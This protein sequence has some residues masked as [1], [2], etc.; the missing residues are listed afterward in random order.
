MI[1]KNKFKVPI[2]EYTVEVELF[3]D[4]KEVREKYPESFESSTLGCTLEYPSA[5]CTVIVPVNNISVIIHE[6]EHVKNLIWKHIG[7]NSQ[8]DNDE[9]DA[10]I[11]GYLMEKIEKFIK[12]HL[13]DA[14]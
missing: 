13:Q 9:P 5:K 12:K 7:Y 8:N 6:L 10:Y 11:L 14:K 2:Y 1:T 4:I 3:D